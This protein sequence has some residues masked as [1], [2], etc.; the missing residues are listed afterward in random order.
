M[1][2]ALRAELAQRNQE[3]ETE[4]YLLVNEQQAADL[5]AGYVPQA[6]KAMVTTMLDWREEDARRAARPVP[7]SKRAGGRGK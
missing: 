2:D 5:A 1:T 6:V 4:F 3:H 7:P